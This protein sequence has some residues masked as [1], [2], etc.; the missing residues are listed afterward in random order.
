VHSSTFESF[1]RAARAR[2]ALGVTVPRHQGTRTLAALFAACY[3][4]RLPVTAISLGIVLA[5]RESGGAYALAGLAAGAF[6]LGLSLTAPLLARLADRRGA[7]VVIVVGSALSGGGLVALAAGLGSLPS[8]AVPPLAL[9]AGAG[10]PPLGAILRALLP[11]LV[12]PERLPR[13]YALEATGQELLFVIGPALL[14]AVV[15]L[16]SARAAVAALGTLLAAGGVVFALVA[17]RRGHVHDA[18]DAR[19]AS[20]LRAPALRA[21]LAMAALVG[22]VFGTVEISTAAALERAGARDATGLVLAIWSAGSLTGGLT[23]ARRTSREARLRLR[24]LLMASVVAALPLPLLVPW[25]AVLTAALF[26]HGLFIAPTFA[27]TYELIPVAAPSRL[28]EAF[29]WMSTSIVGGIALGSAVA[30][31]AVAGGGA[32]VGFGLALAA[33]LGAR[34]VAG[35]ARRVLPRTAAV[36]AD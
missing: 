12:T 10:V 1:A 5:V 17:R 36:P 18:E 9:V 24:S 34:L 13:I 28:T 21:I 11:V 29:A 4:A 33:T 26:V 3:L 30:G 7:P 2:D 15:A 16:G 31:S 19:A 22:I 20:P 27:A 32:A 23:I 35:R 25:P 6:T 14:A 8:V